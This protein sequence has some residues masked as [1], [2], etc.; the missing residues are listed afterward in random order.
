LLHERGDPAAGGMDLMGELKHN[1]SPPGN[2]DGHKGQSET[3]TGTDDDGSETTNERSRPAERSPFEDALQM[4]DG[5]APR[6]FHTQM[7]HRGGCSPDSSTSDSRTEARGHGGHN[8]FDRDRHCSGD[9]YLRDMGSPDTSG[10]DGGRRE[11]PSH[12]H[13][14]KISDMSDAQPEGL[15]SYQ[16]GAHHEDC[17]ESAYSAR[18]LAG[19][20]V[21]NLVA[22]PVR[23]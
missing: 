7:E 3:G 15:Q 12:V 4:D 5:K 10:G 18:N 2:T 22:M 13:K 20:P 23:P 16:L 11:E 19:T 17:S 14:R 6:E 21:R 1:T 9:E 8:A